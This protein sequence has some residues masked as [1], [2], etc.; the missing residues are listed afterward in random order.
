VAGNN[1]KCKSCGQEFRE[2]DIAMHKVKAHGDVNAVQFLSD[3][4]KEDI[5]MK[6]VVRNLYLSGIPIEIISMQVDLDVPAVLKI[7][8]EV[9]K[10]T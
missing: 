2:E 6:V 7:I 10:W 1:V 8:D 9:T 4:N 3:V 5:T